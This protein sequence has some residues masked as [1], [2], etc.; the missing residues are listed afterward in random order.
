[1]NT[2]EKQ[3]EYI[4]KALG[5]NKHKLVNIKLAVAL[6]ML[7]DRTP[8]EMELAIEYAEKLTSEVYLELV[9]K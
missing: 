1:M 7:L 9:N 2:A 3:K 6:S 4:R 8:E 5:T